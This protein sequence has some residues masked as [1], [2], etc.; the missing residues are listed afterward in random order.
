MTTSSPTV[1]PLDSVMVDAV[2]LCGLRENNASH[3]ANNAIKLQQQLDNPQNFAK[4]WKFRGGSGDTRPYYFDRTLILK[5][6]GTAWEG[7]G[8]HCWATGATD[9]ST[10]LLMSADHYSTAFDGMTRQASATSAANSVLTVVGRT[11][12]STDLYNSIHITGGTNFVAG[13]YTIV[14]VTAS[15]NKWT[16]DR[17]CTNGSAATGMTGFYCPELIQNRGGGMRHLGINFE[18]KANSSATTRGVIGYHVVTAA[19]AN[20]PGSYTT[21]QLDFS[22]CSF[23]NF[24][25]GLLFG[26]GMSKFGQKATD[27]DNRT[28]NFADQTSLY[29][30][31][32]YNV[33]D[34]VVVRNRQSVIHTATDVHAYLSGS[35]YRF[36]AGGK[37]RVRGVEMA[38]D[39]GTQRLLTIGSGIDLNNN[40][41]YIFRDFSFDGATRNPQLVVT[42]LDN[43]QFNAINSVIFDGG[44]IS[45]AASNDGLYLVDI[46]SCTTLSLSRIQGNGYVNGIWENSIRLRKGPDETP[47]DNKPLLFVEKCALG[48]T[49]GD[50]TRIIDSVN[51]D[52]GITVVF[53]GCHDGRGNVFEDQ[54][55]VTGS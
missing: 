15:G 39:S 4:T 23:M 11:V 24:D 13:W 42:E 50:Q 47:Y 34:A 26:P 40:G 37:V 29:K 36:D 52:D 5:W 53:R 38:G 46:Q 55:F 14:G 28:D 35:L 2:G 27:W 16:L 49:G 10:I 7:A 18:G 25:Y 1:S 6:L 17:N 12:S 21:G 45:R 19:Q 41:A 48:V 54:T 43:I 32:F 9:L 44:N 30:T 51:S 33:I 20:P 3:G 22:F 8:R 31:I